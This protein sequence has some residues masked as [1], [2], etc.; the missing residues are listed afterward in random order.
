LMTISAGRSFA[1]PGFDISD[2]KSVCV[3]VDARRGVGR[4]ANGMGM[5]CRSENE[6]VLCGSGGVGVDNW[7]SRVE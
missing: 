1:F 4:E 7:D 3:V 6:R 5:F 2:G